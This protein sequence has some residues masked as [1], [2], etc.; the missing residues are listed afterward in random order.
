MSFKI[1][2]SRKREIT[3]FL[4]D[5]VNLQLYLSLDACAEHVIN[6]SLSCVFT[7]FHNSEYLYYKDFQQLIHKIKEKSSCINKMMQDDARCIDF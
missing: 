6:P 5:T 1:R 7:T 2:K 3:L 4:S